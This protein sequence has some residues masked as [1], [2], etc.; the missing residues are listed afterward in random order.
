[1][2]GAKIIHLARRFF[3][4]DIDVDGSEKYRAC[5]FIKCRIRVKP[6]YHTHLIDCI[7]TESQILP[8]DVE[9]IT[10]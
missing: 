9:E 6:G 8:W 2:S 1:M 5:Q 4:R 3:G 10:V 7:Y